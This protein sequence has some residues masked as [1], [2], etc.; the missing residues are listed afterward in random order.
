L[1]GLLKKLYNLS[2]W[3]TAA[4]GLN[5]LSNL[6]I[7]KTLGVEVFG[8][9]FYLS[10]LTG[11]FTLILVI[12]PPN[13]SLI[14]YQDDPEYKYL[15]ARFHTY[16]WLLLWIPVLIFHQL[17]DIPFWLFYL[18]VFSI[19]IQGFFDIS[20]QAENRLTRYYAMLFVQAVVKISLILVAFWLSYLVDFR[21]LV[22]AIVVS[23]LSVSSIY[24]FHYR[25][26]FLEKKPLLH[27][28]SRLIWKHRRLY[29]SYYLNIVLKRLAANLIV[30]LFEPIVTRENLGVYALLVKVYQFIQ[31]LI[32]TIESVF[33]YRENLRTFSAGFRKNGLWVGF[34][35]Q[36]MHIVI[37]MLYMKY[38]D[39]RFYAT[40]IIGMS[41]LCY[42]YVFFVK[43]RAFFLTQFQNLPINLSYLI[44]L[45]FIIVVYALN[46]LDW[47][48]INLTELVLLFSVSSALQMIY[49]IAAE[50]NRSRF[51]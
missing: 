38:L 30:L 6:V 7:A 8:D 14:R 31:G 28:I 36:S 3:N 29:S 26:I 5:F 9:L 1:T 19:S 34:V 39:G 4:A 18:Y 16:A 20:F 33:L 32:R 25:R 40:Y 45:F 48:D 11:I 43:A 47:L 13:Y 49:L 23:Q 15:L 21:A 35:L 51:Q 22:M 27:K 37:G 17:V 10:S 2:V 42:L 50:K 46:R 44:F 24:L 41:F 12:I